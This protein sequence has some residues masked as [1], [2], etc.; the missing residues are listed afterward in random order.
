[1]GRGGTVIVSIL[2]PCS[3]GVLK[4]C[5]RTSFLDQEALSS[6]VFARKKVRAKALFLIQ[7]MAR[8]IKT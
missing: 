4:N 2:I 8:G 5:L 3:V 1:M 7:S 6:R